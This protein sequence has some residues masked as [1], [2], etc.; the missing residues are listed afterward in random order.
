MMD[1][2]VHGF[3]GT[4][5][6]SPALLELRADGTV[7][8]VVT[9]ELKDTAAE[10]AFFRINVTPEEAAALPVVDG[11]IPFDLNSCEVMDRLPEMCGFCLH[12]RR[13]ALLRHARHAEPGAA[14]DGGAR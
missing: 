8:E 10:E 13:Q 1:C 7:P 14:A 12:E 6:Y 9:I 5:I 4:C 3:A 11:R 2:P